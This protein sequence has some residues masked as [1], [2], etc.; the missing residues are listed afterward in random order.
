MNKSSSVSLL[1]RV[2]PAAGLILLIATAA[3]AQE[4]HAHE[5]HFS[6]RGLIQPLGAATL[7]LIIV[8]VALGVFRRANPK[9]MLRW[10]KITGIL[11]L[12]SGVCHALLV[13]FAH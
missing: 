10:H 6:L 11:A 7:T 13:L 3:M 4:A 2:L 8:T 5:E 12:I 9:G 1:C